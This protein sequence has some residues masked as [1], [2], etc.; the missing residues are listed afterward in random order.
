MAS[1]RQTAC[2]RLVTGLACGV[3]LT[4]GRLPSEP[5]WLVPARENGR[6]GSGQD[7][8]P[9]TGHTSSALPGQSQQRLCA[10]GAQGPS[11]RQ[12]LQLDLPLP[13]PPLLQMNPAPSLGTLLPSAE[14][15]W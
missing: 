4:K 5:L 15:S 3:G 7:P 1:S 14:R 2:S 12:P 11:P 10:R 9:A 6:L 13:R 8:P